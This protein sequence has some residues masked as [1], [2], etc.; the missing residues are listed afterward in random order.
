MKR[1]FY[2]EMK[3]EMIELGSQV[4]TTFEHT[5]KFGS[6][7]VGE[8]VDIAD[9]GVVKIKYDKEM[10]ETYY[11]IGSEGLEVGFKYNECWLE[12]L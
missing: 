9:N 7:F 12:C 5:C 11:S 4:Q 2:K 6:F 10:S 8:V 1:I 3:S